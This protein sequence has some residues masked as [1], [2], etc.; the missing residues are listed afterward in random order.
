MTRGSTSR[1]AARLLA[2]AIVAALPA[3]PAAAL[4]E[5]SGDARIVSGDTLEIAGQKIALAGI[6]APEPGQS[7]RRQDGERYDCGRIAA[8]A[9]MDLA[10]GVEVRCRV[11]EAAASGPGNNARVARCSAGGYD[12][13]EGMVYTGWALAD[14]RTGGQLRGLERGAR[15]AGRGLWRGTFEAPWVWRAARAG[16]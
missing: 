5:L 6:D 16:R 1:A 4:A 11:L 8:T 2:A 10:A 14:P 7:C 15:E 3:L 9:L 12:L 13:S